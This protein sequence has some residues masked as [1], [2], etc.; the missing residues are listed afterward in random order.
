MATLSGAWQ[1]LRSAFGDMKPQTM[2][3][4]FM[5]FAENISKHTRNAQGAGKVFGFA[6]DVLL[7]PFKASWAIIKP[8]AKVSAVAT[9]AVP[10]AGGV[11]VAATGAAAGVAAGHGAVAIAKQPIAGVMKIG[12]GI[13]TGLRRHK[14]AAGVIALGA[15]GASLLGWS[16]ARAAA[17]TQEEL[18]AQ[19]AAAQN[20]VINAAQGNTVSYKNSVTREESALLAARQAEAK[21]VS[22]EAARAPVAPP[23]AGTGR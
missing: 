20:D 9:V 8:V 4:G 23:E 13:V 17:N 12:A 3:E 10:A 16:N 6:A 7:A 14:I 15:A 2:R 19:A 18:M 1:S 5:G 21:A 11:A 22:P